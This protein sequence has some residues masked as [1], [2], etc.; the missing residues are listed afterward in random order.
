MPIP[1]LKDRISELEPLWR[2]LWTDEIALL[3]RESDG[4]T[5][6]VRT[7]DC[8]CSG[9]DT[10]RL[11][12]HAGS[13][14]R[15]A[16][17]LYRSLELEPMLEERT[18]GDYRLTLEQR[19][20]AL[21]S[22]ASSAMEGATI[23][24]ESIAHLES[25]FGSQVQSLNE[26]KRVLE[27]AQSQCKEIET[28]VGEPQFKGILAD[29]FRSRWLSVT[30]QF[31][32]WQRRLQPALVNFTAFGA[33][34]LVCYMILV[35]WLP[36]SL[37]INA[38]ALVPVAAA[39][40]RYYMTRHNLRAAIDS[41]RDLISPLDPDE[42]PRSGNWLWA[43]ELESVRGSGDLIE[44][45]LSRVRM[46]GQKAVGYKGGATWAAATIVGATVIT[47][48]VFAVWH[49][50][51]HEAIS[52]SA[53]HGTCVVDRGRILWP[54]PGG[55]VVM[56]G[57]EPLVQGESRAFSQVSILRSESVSQLKRSAGGQSPPLCSEQ[58][59]HAPLLLN[60]SV[61][62]NSLSVEL[63]R[64][65]VLPVFTAPVS[66]DDVEMDGQRLRT[67]GHRG[68][69]SRVD[70]S[71]EQILRNIGR[72]IV[73]CGVNRPVVVD[74]RGYA[75]S[76]EFDCGDLSLRSSDELNV[77]LAEIRRRDV[78]DRLR[79]HVPRGHEPER[80]VVVMEDQPRWGAKSLSDAHKRMT[81]S[82]VFED[83]N[84]SIVERNREALSRYVE[85]EVLSPGD[86]HFS[87][88][89]AAPS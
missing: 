62:N 7:I 30:D 69:G 10:L 66:C 32:T 72:G 28:S 38:L 71:S 29:A 59:H 16:R 87:S 27:V 15:Q 58:S 52:Q 86:C 51:D 19:I 85:I 6:S 80:L 78:I 61:P 34:A 64:L 23:A 55:V 5:A 31:G 40:S 43:Q 47:P 42:K 57:S 25:V 68:G 4:R 84:G 65:I 17:R 21:R 45:G 46:R 81:N 2:E 73:A 9:K 74:V 60:V 24:L 36:A 77:D 56:G 54:G 18:F 48:W 12:A 41:D 79:D 89:A 88:S 11:E 83:R 50:P 75:S 33:L 13:L 49:A 82:R 63:R 39:V 26:L 8:I 22:E 37:L 14:Q 35:L 70:A 3:V 53:S 67:I 76:S 20:E 44:G 1:K